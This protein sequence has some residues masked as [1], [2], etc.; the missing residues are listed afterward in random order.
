MPP[1]K[2]GANCVIV[3]IS[4]HH[5]N[6]RKVADAIASATDGIV[7]EAGSAARESVRDGAL[8]GLGSGIFFGSHHNNL[9]SFAQ[10]LPERVSGAAFLFSTSGTGYEMPRRLGRDYHRTLRAILEGKGY[11]IVGEFACK[12]FDTYG[13]WGRLGGIARGHPDAGDLERA[14]LFAAGLMRRV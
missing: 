4:V 10:S 1:L 11:E 2:P 14:R 6:T 3:C 5:G 12:G 9:L 13:P 8:L 7:L